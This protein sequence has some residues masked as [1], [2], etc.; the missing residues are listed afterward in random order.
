MKGSTTFARSYAMVERMAMPSFILCMPGV[1]PVALEKY[2]YFNSHDIINDEEETFKKFNKT[3]SEIIDELYFVL[4]RDF[5]LEV[6]LY[7]AESIKLSYGLN[8]LDDDRKV[9]VK[10]LWT[11]M[12]GLCY[13]IEPEFELSVD[14]S[15]WFKFAIKPNE[16]YVETERKR[17]NVDI[18]L[19]S[20][21]TWPGVYLYSWQH[22]NVP[23]IS[24]PFEASN[25]V[26]VEV[27]P[28]TIQFQNGVENV[29][30]CFEDIVMSFNC[31]YIC[32][33]VAFNYIADLPLCRSHKEMAC[34][35]EHGLYDPKMEILLGECMRP[36]NAMVF[37]AQV[38]SLRS[39][40]GKGN[41][42][43]IWFRY[44]T[45]KLSVKEEVH[46]IGLATFIGSIG[47][48]L[49]LFLGFSIFDYISHF[50]DKISA[51]LNRGGAGF[52]KPES[53]K[54]RPEPD[55]L[56]KSPN[57]ASKPQARPDPAIPEYF[58]Q[59]ERRPKRAD[60]RLSFLEY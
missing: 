42:T 39:A 30:K 60:R 48:S 49:G 17:K 26:L 20:N 47:G 9:M 16:N 27:I 18:F 34:M 3:P 43:T 15:P 35:Y 33:S 5:E 10:E 58:F 6:G 23:K 54:A 12:T 56:F 52:E 8:H 21:N 38:L 53:S 51:L 41:V 4:A 7:L 24:F 2:G 44:A 57:E 31:S 59:A 1:N 28:A 29:K 14:E 40:S 46:S 25:D 36:A 22:L 37:K 45:G 32:S 13:L 50:I 55:R 19:A 11:G